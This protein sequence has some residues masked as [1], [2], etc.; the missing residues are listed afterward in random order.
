[1]MNSSE[2]QSS[3]EF[4]FLSIS[5][6]ITHPDR[7]PEWQDHW[8]IKMLKNKKL[9]IYKFVIQF[10]RILFLMG[11]LQVHADDIEIY[12]GITSDL[13]Y[14]GISQSSGKPRATLSLDWNR[15]NGMYFGTNISAGEAAG[16]FRREKD[17]SAY[18]GYFTS[19]GKDDAVE[20]SLS[21]YAF[22]GE[23]PR[24]W[25]YLEMRSDYHFAKNV[26][27]TLAYTDDYYGRDIK[28]TY[29]SINWRPE[30]YDS[31]YGL[32][33]LGNTHIKSSY[34]SNNI[35]DYSVGIVTSFDRWDIHLG[36]FY[37]EDEVR[38]VYESSAVGGRTAIQI[39][40][41]IY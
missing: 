38:S 21:Y 14:R 30:I 39:N 15:N 1:M 4:V 19:I 34:F 35:R 31:V 9:S 29:T 23:F 12:G 10:I 16:R 33:T 40:Y 41:A 26:S 37:A 25:D 27:L 13:I 18:A 2:T 17:Y 3:L 32:L 24:S 20:F 5:A 36:Y 8:Q 22:Q 28:N 7:I 6:A 11:I